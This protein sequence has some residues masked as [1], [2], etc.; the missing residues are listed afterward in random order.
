M[1]IIT[2][3]PDHFAV[4]LVGARRTNRELKVVQRKLE[5]PSL[6]FGQF[7][8][9][10]DM[11]PIVAGM[12]G[13]AHLALIT[14]DAQKELE[15]RFPGIVDLYPAK[16]K[17]VGK[18]VGPAIAF[19]A[20]EQYLRVEDVLLGNALNGMV[21]IRHIRFAAVVPKDT[22]TE[23]YRDYLAKQFPTEHNSEWVTVQ[24]IPGSK[25]ETTLR[26]AQFANI[27]LM[28]QLHETSIGSFIDQHREILLSA[29]EAQGL[30]SEPYLPW[31]I[32]STD[33]DDDEAINPDLFLQRAD[34]FWDVYDLKLALLNRKSLTTGKRRERKFIDSVEKGIAQLA[35]YRDYL[36]IPEHAALAKEKYN[37]TF[38]SPH[39][40][41][42]VGNYENVDAK[43]I[44]EARRRFPDLE[45]IDY[46]SLLQLYLIHEDALPTQIKGN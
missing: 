12:S 39:F 34:G 5:D 2:T 33:P 43:K 4:E 1:L 46:D 27:Y 22:S 7:T 41:L 32:P 9:P 31:I 40:T 20:G 42:V 38:S 8:Y 24:L 3:L 30:I 16:I 21:R 11:E 36:S 15:R 10:A 44:A 45:L 29:L 14:S 17:N 25:A 19:P 18:N 26:A 35:H 6:Y 28:N 23:E 37:V 13:L